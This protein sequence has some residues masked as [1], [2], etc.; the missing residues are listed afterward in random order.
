[1]HSGATII[2]Q[3]VKNSN[4]I[5]SSN[6]DE[7]VCRYFD[8]CYCYCRFEEQFRLLHP[9]DQQKRGNNSCDK[10]YPKPCRICLSAFWK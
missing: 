2:D 9:N 7:I 5:W 3:R 8:N 4:E 6:I 10:R 1:M